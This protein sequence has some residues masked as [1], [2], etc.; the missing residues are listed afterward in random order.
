MPERPI[1]PDG[2]SGA[3]RAKRP[4]QPIS[5]PKASD[6]EG[7]SRAQAQQAAER[8]DRQA[9]RAQK[10]R[11]RRQKQKDPKR[12]ELSA[13]QLERK[14][15]FA[16]SFF[17]SDPELWQLLKDAIKNSWPPRKFQAEL[18]DTKWF[19]KHSDIYRQNY[20]LKHTDPSTYKERLGNYATTLKNLAGQWGADLTKKELRELAEEAYLMGWDEAQMMDAIAPQVRPSKQGHYGGELSGIEQ[21]LRQTALNNG[22]RLNDAQLT[23]WMRNIV[24]GNADVRQFETFIRG[25]AAKT[26]GAYGEEILGGMDAVDVAAPY[27]Q[28]MSEILELNPADVNMYDRTI[29]QALSHKDEKGNPA[30]MSI[31]DFEDSLRFDKRWQYTDNARETMKSYAIDLGKMWGVL[32]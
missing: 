11:R 22:V 14:Y 10:N 3:D 1:I 5:P 28:S 6:S 4:P 9:R 32:S 20:A 12:D 21:Q 2:A 19:Q 23:K 17:K 26:F 16:Y 31:S 25:V 18:Q 24:R 30:P 8:A 15:G 29:R 13:K 27:I 7:P